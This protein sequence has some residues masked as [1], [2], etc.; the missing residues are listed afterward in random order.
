MRRRAGGQSR[1]AAPAYTTTP[2]ACCGS[3][4]ARVTI[5]TVG[6]TKETRYIPAYIMYAY[7]PSAVSIHPRD[8]ANLSSRRGRQESGV[9]V[10]A[11]ARCSPFPLSGRSP[12]R[13]RVLDVP[14]DSRSEQPPA[15]AD[16][17]ERTGAPLLFDHTWDKLPQ[18]QR[19][20]SDGQSRPSRP[21]RFNAFLDYRWRIT[22]VRWTSLRCSTSLTAKL[23]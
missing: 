19:G 13:P 23:S 10:C 20:P 15:S 1:I 6:N 18:S 21:H 22:A 2:L 8:A 12:L 16:V 9:T 14:F 3:I 11:A 4:A 5:S 17:R 7:S